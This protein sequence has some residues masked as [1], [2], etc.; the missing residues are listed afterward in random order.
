MWSELDLEELD[1]EDGAY[2]AEASP[3]EI[4]ELV[5]MLRLE[6]YNQ[7]RPCGPKPLRRRLAQHYGTSLPSERTIARILER[8]ALSRGRTGRYPGEDA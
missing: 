4:E 2:V 8:N 1:R 6:L 7:G 3:E 5:C